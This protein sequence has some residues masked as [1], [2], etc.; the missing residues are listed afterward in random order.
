MKPPPSLEQQIAAVPPAPIAR[1]IALLR[2]WGVRIEPLPSGRWR[3]I[4][5]TSVELSD[6]DVQRLYRY[7]AASLSPART[8]GAA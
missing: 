6:D 4:G 1:A 5:P 2:G 3:K 7:K 8:G